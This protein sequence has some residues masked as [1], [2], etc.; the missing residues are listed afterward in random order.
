MFSMDISIQGMDR[1]LKQFE[2]IA[3]APESREM[4]NRLLDNAKDLRNKIRSRVPKGET[5]NLYNAIEARRFRRKIAGYPAVFVRVDRKKAPHYHLVEF[6][7]EGIRW[8]K[9]GLMKFK[10]GEQWVVTRYVAKMPAQPF[11]RPTVDEN[12]YRVTKR[13]MDDVETVIKK[14]SGEG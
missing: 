1:L 6:G 10:I 7:T 14:A 12:R 8:S 3:G 4:E 2:Q 11:F 5:K 13:I 9:K